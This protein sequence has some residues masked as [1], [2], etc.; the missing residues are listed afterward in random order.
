M[1]Q[2][3]Q[4]GQVSKPRGKMLVAENFQLKSVKCVVCNQ[5]NYQKLF[6]IRGFNIVKCL[7]C[8]MIYTNPCPTEEELKRLYITGRYRPVERRLRQLKSKLR[9][10]LFE[11][12]ARIYGKFLDIGCLQGDFGRAVIN[13]RNWDYFGIDLHPGM[14]DYAISL[15]L[16]VSQGTLS[17]LNF[18]DNTFARYYVASSG[19]SL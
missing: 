17:D 12:F 1:W 7:N 6:D 10:K 3:N 2:R 8:G 5:D 14:I 4:G 19:T 16:N 15:N 13:N 18:S 9:V 11:R